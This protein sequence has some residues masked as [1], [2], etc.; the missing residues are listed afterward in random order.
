MRR[1]VNQL[2]LKDIIERLKFLSSESEYFFWIFYFP[3]LNVSQHHD[4]NWT[5][6]SPHTIPAAQK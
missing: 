2:I 3:F 1:Y 6:I 4:K 5:F